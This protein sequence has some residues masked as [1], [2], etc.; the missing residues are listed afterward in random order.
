MWKVLVMVIAITAMPYTCRC[1]TPKEQKKEQK[2]E[3]KKERYKG[4]TALA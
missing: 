1:R 3:Q 4:P 2:Q